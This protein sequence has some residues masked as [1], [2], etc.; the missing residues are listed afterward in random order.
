MIQQTESGGSYPRDFIITG[1]SKFLLAV[2]RYEGG[3]V[4]FRLDPDT[5]MLTELCSRVPAPEAVSV[6]LA[7]EAVSV[8]LAPPV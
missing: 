6:V 4:S 8:V 5:G 3:L 1:D 2:N 7:P